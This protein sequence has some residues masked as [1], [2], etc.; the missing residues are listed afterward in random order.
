MFDAMGATFVNGLDPAHKVQVETVSAKGSPTVSFNGQKYHLDGN[1]IYLDGELSDAQASSSQFI[2]NNV[3]EALEAISVG[4]EATTTKTLLIAPGV[5]WVDDPDD[6]T[7]RTSDYGAPYGMTIDC[8]SICIKGLTVNPEYV[9]LAC[10]RGQTQGSVGNFTML[11]LIA[12]EVETSNITFGNYCNVDLVYP[13]KRSYNKEKRKSAIVQAQLVHTTADKVFAQNCRFISRLNMNPITGGH[14][15]LY[16]D[17]Y[18]ECTDDALAGSAI[19]LNC[20]FTFFSSKPFYSAAHYGAVFLGCKIK[21]LV[22]GTQYF[23]KA[24]GGITLIDTEITSE[25]GLDEIKYNYVPRTDSW[26]E[27]GNRLN[28]EPINIAG[29]TDITGKY[30]LNAYKVTL[31]GKIVYN[32]ANLLAGDDNWDPLNQREIIPEEYLGM[33]THMELN[34]SK[35]QDKAEVKF[36]RWG[37]YPA[38]E[39]EIRKVAYSGLLWQRPVMS[40]ITPTGNFTADIASSYKR[41]T[42]YVGEISAKLP[43][44]LQARANIRYEAYLYEAPG[45]DQ[46]PEIHLDKTK[47]GLVVD[48]KLSPSVS[49]TSDSKDR[50]IITWYRYLAE[51]LSDTI[52][53]IWGSAGS[54]SAEI[55]QLGN[56]DRDMHILAIVTPRYNDSKCGEDMIAKYEETIQATILP[57][58]FSQERNYSTDFSNIPV[59]YQPKLSKG[60]WTFDAY[61]P[62]DTNAQD[63]TPTPKKA[64]YYGTGV[65]GCKGQG[66]SE[67]TKGARCF[68]TPCREKT[69]NMKAVVKIDPGK[70]KGQ[71]FGSATD[72]YL[73]IYIKFDPESLT[74][75]GVRIERTPDYDGAVAFQLVKFTK[76]EVRKLGDPVISNCYVSTCTVTLEMKGNEL[77]ATATTNAN[78]PKPESPEIETEVYLNVTVAKNEFG[79]FGLQHTGSTGPSA[80]MIHNVELTFF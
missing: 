4:P 60:A 8:P 66:L 67:L 5:Y 69:D 40:T 59:R 16:K 26:Y 12:Q 37:G 19:Y 57:A 55:Y 7:V 13:L 76:G 3:R 18:M 17:C 79:A 47:K 1:T 30:L 80:S 71:G 68:Y 33:P 32:I 56:A 28:G 50:S 10:N 54:K 63:W 34:L 52:P 29:G 14:R 45:F 64:W 43:S 46:Y 78:R 61:K 23:T 44:G 53:V 65:D 39:E 20:N 42:P 21:S 24:E 6:P 36:Y 58:I 41:P 27:S 51:D 2:Y 48:Y 22:S 11:R 75:Y 62:A 72:Q 35:E 73:D 15:S 9:V 70:S 77:V 74:G 49:E 31:D 38:N 25:T